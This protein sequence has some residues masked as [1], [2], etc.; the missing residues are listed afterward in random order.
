[1][2]PGTTA[3]GG[4]ANTTLIVSGCAQGSAAARI[5]SDLVSGSFSDWYLPSKDELNRLYGQRNSVGGFGTAPYWSSTE[6]N[7]STAALQFFSSGSQLNAS[8]STNAMIRAVRA[9]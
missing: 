3:S 9:F 4:Q 8:K 6:N 1:L 7:G 5:C 2:I